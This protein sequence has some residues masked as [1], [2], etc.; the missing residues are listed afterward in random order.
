MASMKELSSKG[1]TIEESIVKCKYEDH[2]LHIK[3][4]QG[5]VER[6]LGRRFIAI[7]SVEWEIQLKHNRREKGVYTIY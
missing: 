1:A 7:A 2:Y 3:I 6:N 4:R 5:I